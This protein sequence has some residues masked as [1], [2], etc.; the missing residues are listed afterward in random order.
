MQYQ[1]SHLL[2]LLLRLLKTKTLNSLNEGN[3]LDK[4]KLYSRTTNVNVYSKRQSCEE[5]TMI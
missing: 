3:P 1:T 4:C 2:S 5:P